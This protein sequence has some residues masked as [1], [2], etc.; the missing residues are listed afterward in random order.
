[1]IQSIKIAKEEDKEISF[2]CSDGLFSISIHKEEDDS[3]N[4]TT[5]VTLTYDV[6]ECTVIVTDTPEFILFEIDDNIDEEDDDDVLN[7]YE[8]DLDD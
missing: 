6:F 3:F 4:K 8:D 5:D 1:M 2:D 7:V